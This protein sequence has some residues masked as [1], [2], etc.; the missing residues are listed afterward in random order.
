MVEA[1]DQTQIRELFARGYS[2]GECLLRAVGGVEGPEREALI[3]AV[4]GFADGRAVTCS[5][6]LAGLL[7]LS[8]RRPTDESGP[9]APTTDWL[10]AFVPPSVSRLR[11]S[12]RERMLSEFRHRFESRAAKRLGGTRC[13]MAFPGDDPEPISSAFSRA[14]EGCIELAEHTARDLSQLLPQETVSS[15][16]R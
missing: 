13:R 6:L 10:D 5:L 14:Q 4:Q 8:E 12:R 16:P 9:S 11:E 7:A 2:C 15:R 3:R 1:R